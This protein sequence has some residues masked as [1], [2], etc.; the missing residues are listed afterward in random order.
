M[1]GGAAA[2]VSGARRCIAGDEA[3]V[4]RA[5]QVGERRAGDVDV[6]GIEGVEHRVGTVEDVGHPGR[7]PGL[8]E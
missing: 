7:G 3:L 5:Q 2:D 8:A 6:E 4:R 1:A